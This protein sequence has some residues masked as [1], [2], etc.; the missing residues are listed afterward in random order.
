MIIVI[1]FGSISLE[2]GDNMTKKDI[3]P[4]HHQ[5]TEFLRGKASQ[6]FDEVV[7]K[8]GVVLVNKNSKP[9]S[10]IISYD[11][12]CKLKDKGADI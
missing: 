12:Y 9:H 8:D 7:K 11:R 6:I 4:I 5:M 2:R 1:T 3:V 10:I